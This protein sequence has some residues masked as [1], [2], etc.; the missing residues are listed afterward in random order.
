M[1]SKP[2]PELFYS[3]ISRLGIQ[4]S[5]TLIFE[6]S[7]SEIKSAENAGVGK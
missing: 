2:D 7:I 6:D 5:E 4:P 3:A 1:K